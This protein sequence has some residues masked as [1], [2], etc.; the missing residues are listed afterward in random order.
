MSHA[1]RLA[2][3]FSNAK[4]KVIPGAKTYVMV[5]KPKELAS[6]IAAFIRN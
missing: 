4:L 3:D 6:E 5:D 1:E 2:A